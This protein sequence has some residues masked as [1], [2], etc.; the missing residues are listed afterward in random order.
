MPQQP[1]Y[2]CAVFKCAAFK[3]AV[4]KCAVF[5]CAAFKCAVFKCAALLSLC[6]IQM[7]S[8]RNKATRQPPACA[9]QRV[10]KSATVFENSVSF[11]YG[12]SYVLILILVSYSLTIF[13]S[14]AIL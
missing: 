14:C 10:S 7:G 9:V 13:T 8:H 1:P 2:P 12:T 6:S 11:Q 4:F 5:K 3:C